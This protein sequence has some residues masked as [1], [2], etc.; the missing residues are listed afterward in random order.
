[1][2][3]KKIIVNPFQINC[4][5]YYD[6]IKGEGI[7]IDPAVYEKYEGDEILNFI[8]ENKIKIKY[9]INTHGHIDHILGNKFAME[10][11]NCPLL[12]HKDDLFI[13]NNVKMQGM[14]YGIDIEGTPPPDDFI[15]DDLVLKIGNAKINFIHTPGHTP[16]G[17]CVADYK[18]KN[19]FCGDTIFRGTIG[20]TDLPGGNTDILLDSIRNK[21]F[22]LCSD[23][24][25][26][27]PGHMEET[28][29]GKEK[30]YNPFFK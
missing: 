26:L 5:I 21:L 12:I 22:T 11:F 8:K 29:I 16:G 10:N 24:C 30:R 20:R 6:E 25:K 28:T 23:E 17:V 14:I 3:I 27:F 9:I 15:T 7:I 19:I 4:Y 2:K 1:M 13:L 18:N